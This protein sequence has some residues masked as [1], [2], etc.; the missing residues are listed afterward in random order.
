MW[1]SK[2]LCAASDDSC[3][4]LFLETYCERQLAEINEPVNMDSGCMGESGV[5][6]KFML[7]VPTF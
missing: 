5:I 4:N 3:K 2:T 7:L 6:S 1:P